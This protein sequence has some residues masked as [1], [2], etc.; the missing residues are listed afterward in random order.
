MR[1]ILASRRPLLALIILSPGIAEIM[2]GSTPIDRVVY[3]PLGFTIGVLGLLGLYGA[4]VL[5]V[6]EITVIW[7][8]GW[9]TVLLLG[10]AYGVLE[11][12]VGFHTFT[13]S[14][15]T[16]AGPLAGYGAFLGINSVWAVGL[17]LFHAL[18]SIALPILLVGLLYPESKSRRWFDRGA[19]EVLGVIYVATVAIGFGAVP[20]RPGPIPLLVELGAVAVFVVLA[21]RVPANLLLSSPGPRRA[22]PVWFGIAGAATFLAWLLVDTIGPHRIP[23]A[24]L[25]G[26]LVGVTGGILWFVRSRTGTIDVEWTQYVFAVGALV[27]LILWDVLLEFILVPGILVV[28]AVAV[29]FLYRL[30]RKLLARRAQ[31][32]GPVGVSG[33]PGIG[34]QTG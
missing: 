24:L 18:Y 7:K 17:T 19:L 33:P 13:G 28:A 2:T 1:Y 10:A 31:G 8:K 25:V 11:E 27:D 12:G 30:R 15:A 6:R 34:P 5:L 22:A 14:N 3:D 9:P 4:G 26:F 20:Y 32:V 21:S 23:P 29:L 16:A